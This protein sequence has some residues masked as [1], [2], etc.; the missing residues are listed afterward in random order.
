VVNGINSSKTRRLLQAL[1]LTSAL[2]VALAFGTARAEAAGGNYTLDGGTGLQQ[3]QV[4]RA[5]NASAFPWSIVPG[6]VV[7][8]IRRGTDSY[9][10]PGH[11]WLDADLLDSGVFSWGVV[12]H[13]YAHQVD[14]LL[15]DADKRGQLAGLGG[16]AWWAAGAAAAAP[17]GALA[18]AELTSERF[19]SKLAWSYWPSSRNSMRPTSSNDES[20]AMAP[21]PFRA[22]LGRVLSQG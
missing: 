4:V 10:T 19:A 15:L 13:E 16:T 11:I 18:H 9:A 8:H 17:N 21:A 20:A 5:L 22:L 2:V 14:F 1:L 3:K 12:Q 6:P 7:V